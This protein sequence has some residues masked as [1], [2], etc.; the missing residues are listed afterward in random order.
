MFTSTIGTPLDGSNVTH[1]LHA[2]LRRAGLPSLRF[3]D[4]RH[5]A[6]S[7][8]LLRSIHPHC[9]FVEIL[10]HSQISLTLNTYSHASQA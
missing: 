1:R 10:G 3:H 9:L 6:A 2:I 5:T 8:M 7:L 4:L